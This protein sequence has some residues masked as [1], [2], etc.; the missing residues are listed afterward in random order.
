VESNNGYAK[1][2]LKVFGGYRRLQDAGG[3]II[4]HIGSGA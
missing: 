1:R 4:P 3:S 2:A